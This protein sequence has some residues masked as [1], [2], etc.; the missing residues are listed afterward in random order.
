MV[1]LNPVNQLES[2]KDLIA[3]MSAG[4]VQLLILA[5]VNPLFDSPSDLDFAKA[6]ESVPLRIHHGL[7]QDETAEHCHWH[8]NQADYLEAWGDTR[9]FDGT[10]SLVQP[11]IAPL[12]DGKSLHDLLAVLSGEPQASGHEI[13][14]RYW[15]KQ[16]SGADFDMFWRRSLHDGFVADTAYSPKQVAAKSANLAQPP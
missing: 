7:Y 10:V 15:Q 12:Y 9:A 4:K 1:I 6:F 8:I 13:V 14:Q 2:F 11:L 16:H 3:D 5:G